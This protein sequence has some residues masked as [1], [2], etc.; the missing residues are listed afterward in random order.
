[1]RSQ[2]V[3]NPGKGRTKRHHRPCH[4]GISPGGLG[5]QQGPP[6]ATTLVGHP[7]SGGFHQPVPLDLHPCPFPILPA[8]EQEN[9]FKSIT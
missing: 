6:V 5:W 3:H 1:M 7:A 8:I 4:A 9:N 2:T